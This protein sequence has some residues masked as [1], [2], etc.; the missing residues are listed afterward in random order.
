MAPKYAAMRDRMSWLNART[1]RVI[2][3]CAARVNPFFDFKPGFLTLIGKLPD[4][5]PA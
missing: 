2:C 5:A 1:G 4:S 3:Q